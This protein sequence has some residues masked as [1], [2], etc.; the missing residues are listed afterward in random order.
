[1]RV[2]HTVGQAE[3]HPSKVVGQKAAFHQRLASPC[4]EG[5]RC[6]HQRGGIDASRVTGGRTRRL[7]KPSAR[8]TGKRLERLAGTRGN[9]DGA[10]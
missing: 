7:A 2:C 6:H 3:D 9:S 5:S 1:M 4:P 10:K 8:L